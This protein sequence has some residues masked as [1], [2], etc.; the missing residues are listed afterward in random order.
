MIATARLRLI[1][2]TAAHFEAL[3]ESEAR[4]AAALGVTAAEE[5]L[6]FDAAR[7]AMAQAGEFLAEHPEAARWWTYWF[8][9]AADARLIGLGGFKGAPAEGVVEIG[10]ALAP[11]YRAQG[12][13]SEAAEGMIAFARAHAVERILAHTLPE[14]NRST[15]VLERLGFACEGAVVDPEDGVIWRWSLARG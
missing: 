12:L 4:L 14:A 15:A 7:A 11:A 5:W 8:V 10:Y 9:H 6:E 1:P 3:A 13:A 2:A